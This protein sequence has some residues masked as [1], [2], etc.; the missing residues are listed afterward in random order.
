MFAKHGSGLSGI[1]H[2][3]SRKQLPIMCPKSLGNAIYL[4]LLVLML[5]SWWYSQE[6]GTNLLCHQNFERIEVQCPITPITCLYKLAYMWTIIAS[7]CHL[8][9]W[10]PRMHQK[11]IHYL[12]IVLLKK[13]MGDFIYQIL[14]FAIF[15]TWMC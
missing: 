9:L 13:F 7:V 2:C 6:H 10:M 14:L 11:C 3:M 8:I 1:D 15:H 4:D 5:M 12:C